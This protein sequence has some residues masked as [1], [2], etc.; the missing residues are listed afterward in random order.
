MWA[1]KWPFSFPESYEAPRYMADVDLMHLKSIF[2]IDLGWYLMYFRARFYYNIEFH[3]WTLYAFK[4]NIIY[5]C[6]C[7][8]IC[9]ENILSTIKATI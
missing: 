4:I 8:C 2:G 9:K 7:T 5:I 6:T 3:L 1:K